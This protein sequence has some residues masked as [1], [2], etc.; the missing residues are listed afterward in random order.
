MEF[1]LPKVTK[2]AI[3]K[4]SKKSP[5]TKVDFAVDYF[6]YSSLALLGVNPIMFKIT[7]KNRQTIDSTTSIS[8]IIGKSFHKALEAYYGGNDEVVISTESEAIEMGLKIGMDYLEKYN[9][10]WIKY[11]ETVPNKQKAQEILAFTFNAYVKENPYDNGDQLLST[12]EKIVEN[13]NVEWRGKQVELPIALKCYPDKIIKRDEKLRIV[14]YKTVTSFSKPDKI[15]G[16]KMLQT[17]VLYFCVYAKYGMEPY[18]MIF[19]EVKKTK[20][21]DG[22][23]QVKRYEIVYEENELFFD[24]FFRYY[25]DSIK[26]LNGEAVYLPNVDAMFDGDISIIAY[27]HRLDEEEEVAKQMKLMKVDNITELLKKKIHSANSMKKF[28]TTVEKEFIS[29]KNL[30]YSKMKN[31]EKIQTKL[32]EHGMMLQYDSMIAGHSFD[33]YRYTPSIGLKMKKLESY[34]ADIE[35]VIGRSGVRIL[36]PIPNTS[37]VGFEVP[38]LDRTFPTEKGKPDGYKLAIGCDVMGETYRFDITQAPHMLVAGSTGSGK[39]VCLSSFISQL[40]TIPNTELHLFD[41]KIIELA[42]FKNYPGVV[43]YQKEASKIA[44]SLNKL[45]DEMEN[46]YRKLE[47]LGVKNMSE[48]DM[49]R[50]FVFIDEFGDLIMSSDFGKEISDCIQILAQKA[51]SAGIH[52]I[53]ATQ[54]PSVKIING[55]IKTNFPTKAVFRTAK[56]IDSR[57][58]L[59]DDGAEKLL[60]SGDMIFSSQDGNIRL[61]GYR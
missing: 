59:D 23:E 44:L 47:K 61:Q 5:T 30:N 9:D 53:I 55:D 56:A 42:H 38:K 48:T 25:E 24:F 29:A 58:V 18:S 3:S 11:T 32:M 19:E 57:V 20:N 31:E 60:G 28:L 26:F 35:Q 10:G 22:G 2:R 46:R 54:R 51:R 40:S 50:K 17:I 27:I 12:E 49:K 45:I 52:L 36:A 7:Y 43:E 8:S 16:R 33:L 1:K 21:R 15:D 37:F 13:I 4:D 39:S 6:S 34:T 41:P 14:D